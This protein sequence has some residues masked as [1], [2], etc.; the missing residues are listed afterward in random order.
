MKR[1]VGLDVSVGQ[2]IKRQFVARVL[3]YSSRSLSQCRHSRRRD[4]R[5]RH[6]LAQEVP[7]ESGQRARRGQLGGG[8]D[9]GGRDGGRGDQHV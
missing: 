8:G 7:G 1:L 6:V 3:E 2:F 4:G 9:G 5:V